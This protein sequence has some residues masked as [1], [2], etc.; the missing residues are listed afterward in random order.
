MLPMKL[1][2]THYSYWPEVLQVAPTGTEN[3]VYVHQI[4][5]HLHRF[6][7]NALDSS[8]S[9]WGGLWALSYIVL[10]VVLLPFMALSAVYFSLISKE[11]AA[12]HLLI[13][14]GIPSICCLMGALALNLLTL[15]NGVSTL[16][17][18]RAAQDVIVSPN[19]SSIAQQ[20]DISSQAT[21]LQE[22]A[23]A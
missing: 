22:I 3:S 11:Y 15:G 7:A 12:A 23:Q 18:R 2:S 20:S 4:K 19:A 10:S 6:I 21:D 17:A 1:P 8:S 13:T 9:P 14:Q 5:T 16:C